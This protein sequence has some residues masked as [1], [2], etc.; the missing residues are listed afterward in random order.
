[1][2]KSSPIKLFFAV[3]IFFQ[4]TVTPTY[5]EGLRLSLN[6]VF[7]PIQDIILLENL[8]LIA[9]F[10]DGTN[11]SAL[12]TDSASGKVMLARQDSSVE[13]QGKR[14]KFH[15]RDE[16]YIYLIDENA[17]QYRIVVSSPST[18]LQSSSTPYPEAAVEVESNYAKELTEAKKIALAF[19]LPKY[20]VE[21]LRT[22]PEIK[23]SRA[24]RKGWLLNEKLPKIFF[25]LTP[26]ERGD[27]IL[28][29]DGIPAHNVDKLLKHVKLKG[30]IAKFDVEIQRNKKLKLI[31]VY[32]K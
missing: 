14:L 20:L 28:S 31:R 25:S 11:V 7:W 3:I 2:I 21:N 13:F 24:G 19:G 27:L 1:M 9:F 26:F 23:L 10:D 32:M 12:I 4:T 18:V 30:G 17:V 15:K 8:G 6:D 5:G 22:V 29:I 16:N